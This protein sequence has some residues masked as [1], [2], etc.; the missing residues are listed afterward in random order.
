MKKSCLHLACNQELEVQQ[1]YDF[2]L[3]TI[4]VQKDIRRGETAEIQCSLK[5]VLRRCSLSPSLLP[6]LGKGMQRL[7]KGA[8]LKPNPLSP[9]QGGFSF[10]LQLVVG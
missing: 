9:S 2:T 8:P 5:R 6:T 4:P 10:V 1:A 3:E 7:D